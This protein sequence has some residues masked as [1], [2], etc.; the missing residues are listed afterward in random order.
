VK[1]TPI[2]L[3]SKYPNLPKCFAA[4]YYSMTMPPCAD[5]ATVSQRRYSTAE[6]AKSKIPQKRTS[7]EGQLKPNERLS[8][9]Q[10]IPKQTETPD[11]TPDT[12]FQPL[13]PRDSI[14]RHRHLRNRPWL[15]PV[16]PSSPESSRA[17]A[18]AL[19]PSPTRYLRLRRTNS[20]SASSP[21]PIL[22]PDGWLLVPSHLGR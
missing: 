19:A 22:L 17:A 5:E 21:P 10:P 7:R 13:T 18:A 20:A 3:V 14:L 9:S 11:N 15:Q 2:K 1:H 4:E 6:P 12:L 8:L 16:A